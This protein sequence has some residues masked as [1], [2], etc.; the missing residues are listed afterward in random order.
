MDTSTFK[1]G[2]K[3]NGVTGVAYVKAPEGELTKLLKSQGAALPPPSTDKLA[4]WRKELAAVTA[5]LFKDPSDNSPW[6]KKKEDLEIAIF[7]EQLR[8]EEDTGTAHL[9]LGYA[10]FCSGNLDSAKQHFRKSLDLR[11]DS[12]EAMLGLARCELWWARTSEETEQL[13]LEAIRKNSKM[14]NVCDWPGNDLNLWVGAHYM[15]KGDPGRAVAYLRRAVEL[16]PKGCMV[17]EYLGR[18]YLEAGYLDDAIAAL[19]REVA[20]APSRYAFHIYLAPIYAARG[21]R[22]K[23]AYH[24]DQ[25]NYNN[26]GRVILGPEAVQDIQRQVRTPKPVPIPVLSAQ[27]P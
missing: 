22:D 13:L 20:V 3:F 7:E 6:W 23:A 16:N 12:A 19:E 10:Y 27:Q 18:A 21:N 25:A 26:P 5:Q 4:A 9:R 17:N 11:K 1:S 14:T 15:R 2:V 8:Q 24:R